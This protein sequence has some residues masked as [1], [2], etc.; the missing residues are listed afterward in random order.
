[1]TLISFQLAQHARLPWM[2]TLSFVF[3]SYVPVT[4]VNCRK[5]ASNK[6]RLRKQVVVANL[7]S[8]KNENLCFGKCDK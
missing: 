7:S 8:N 4:H 2:Q 5:E 3:V 6:K 1:M